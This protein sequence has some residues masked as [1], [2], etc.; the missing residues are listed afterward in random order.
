MPLVE[1]DPD[2]ILFLADYFRGRSLERLGRLEEAR[3]VLDRAAARQPDNPAPR[4]D[5]AR[6]LMALGR[7]GEARRAIERVLKIRPRDRQALRLLG[8]LEEAA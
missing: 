2:K 4:T 7:S 8:R 3:A 1:I 6:V 5:L